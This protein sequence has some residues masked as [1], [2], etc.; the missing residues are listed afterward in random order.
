M[1]FLFFFFFSASFLNDTKETETSRKSQERDIS[2]PFQG[3]K[4]EPLL[5]Y[6]HSQ[7][8]LR[9]LWYSRDH[10]DLFCKKTQ[11]VRLKLALSQL[12]QRELTAKH[13]IEND[14]PSLEKATGLSPVLIVKDLPGFYFV[15]LPW[16]LC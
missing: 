15:S 11:G 9:S 14:D 3:Q 7:R 2:L 12:S 13:R 10:R 8:L 16:A 4:P 5:T 6:K 1:F